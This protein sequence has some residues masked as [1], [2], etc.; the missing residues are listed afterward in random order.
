MNTSAVSVLN[1][2]SRQPEGKCIIVSDI[3]I[4]PGKTA[5]ELTDYDINGDNQ[6]TIYGD[7]T[8]QDPIRMDIQADFIRI[9]AFDFSANQLRSVSVEGNRAIY[10]NQLGITKPGFYFLR[11]ESGSET[12]TVKLKITY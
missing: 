3:T 9:T 6:P 7:L 5:V 4:Y 11:L 12:K 8:L 2:G 10:P 1:Y